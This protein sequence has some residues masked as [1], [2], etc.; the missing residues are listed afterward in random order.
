MLIDESQ[1]PEI[2]THNG[3]VQKHLPN[4]K[5]KKASVKMEQ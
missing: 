3:Y 5:E 4:T 1:I 2:L